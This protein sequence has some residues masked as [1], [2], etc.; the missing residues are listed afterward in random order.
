MSGRYFY[1]KLKVL[2]TIVHK[3]IRLYCKTELT[4]KMTYQQLACKVLKILLFSSKQLIVK[5]VYHEHLLK[6]V[7][8]TAGCFVGSP[9]HQTV[10]VLRDQNKNKSSKQL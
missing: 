8:K 4:V 7:S 3:S 5:F 1:I 2:V 9:L 6:T 10:C